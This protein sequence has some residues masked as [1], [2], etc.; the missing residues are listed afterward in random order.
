MF[1]G[2]EL[3]TNVIC[4]IL[5]LIYI[6]VTKHYYTLLYEVAYSLYIFFT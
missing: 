6:D 5:L 3:K 1:A 4:Y 2:V